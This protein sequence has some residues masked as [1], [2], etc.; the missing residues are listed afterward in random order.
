MGK[1][2]IYWLES[3]IISVRS[4]RFRTVL[5]QR[6]IEERREAEFSVLAARK[7][8]RELSFLFSYPL[9]PPRSFTRPIFR[10]VFDSRS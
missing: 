1:V 8:E 4:K 7:M 3:N 10:A 9:P 6:K 2:E 5:E